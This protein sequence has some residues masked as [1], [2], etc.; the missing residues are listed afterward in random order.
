[1]SRTFTVAPPPAAVLDYLKDFSHAEEWDPGTQTCTRLDEGPVRVGSR[2]HNDS[3]IAGRSISLTY[4]LAELAT[5]RVVFVGTNENAKSTDTI[6][7]VSHGDGS[8]ITYQAVIEVHGLAKLAEP[9]TKVL[10]EK[11]GNDTVKEM[12]AVLDGLASA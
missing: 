4:E 2:W 9:L 11:I 8:E 12:T 5:D 6:T 1:M 10:F 7:V 3:K